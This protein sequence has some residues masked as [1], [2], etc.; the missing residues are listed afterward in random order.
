MAGLVDY[1]SSDEEGSVHEDIPQ[2]SSNTAESTLFIN[3]NTNGTTKDVQPHATKLPPAEN[4]RIIALPSN[5]K[6]DAPLVGPQ[7]GPAEAT[8]LPELEDVMNE[9][10]D[11]EPQSPYSANR[12]LLR[13]L[14]LPTVPNYDIPPSPPGSPMASTNAKF[15]HFLELK[16]QGTH[17]NEKLAK[18]A[19]LKNPSLMQKLMDFADI[20]EMEQYET[21]L[22]KYLWNPSGFPEYAYKEELA[23]TQQD[24]LMEILEQKKARGQR[25]A[26]DFV[27]A[28]ASGD[29]SHSG[30]QSAGG[31]NGKGQQ[32]AAERIMAGLD[33]G[34][35]NSPHTQGLKRK[36][37]SV[38][39]ESHRESNQASI[40]ANMPFKGGKGNLKRDRAGTIEESESYKKPRRSERLS[41]PGNTPISN[42]Q[43]LPSPVTHQE[44]S[45]SS[46][47]F[48]DGTATPPEGRP[49]QILHRTPEPTEHFFKESQ[50]FSSP[51]FCFSQVKTQEL[52]QSQTKDVEDEE[53]V[54]GYLIPVNHK[55]GELL[56]LRKRSACPLPGKNSDIGNSR[57]G[58]DLNKEEDTYEATK[59]MG[60]ASR[61]Y[62]IGRHPECDLMI[63]DIKVSNRHCLI[64]T[65]NQEGL[66][67]A[68][69][70]DLSSNGTFIK[71]NVIGRNKHRQLEDGDEIQ[72]LDDARFV[73][74]YPKLRETSKFFQKYTVLEKL[75]SGHYATV[76]LCIEKATGQRFAVKIFTRKPGIGE[77][78]KIEGLQQEI[79]MLMGVSHPYVLC[80]KDIF[81]EPDATYLVLE[82][83]AEGELFNWIVQK[84]KLTEQE[85]RKIF[86][87]LFEG[88]KYLHERGIVHRDIKPENILMTDEDLHVK[89]ADFGLAK[90]IGEASFTTTICGTPSYVAPEII[91]DSNHRRYTRA[92]DIWSLGVV[93]YICLCG[94][95]PF[96]DELY[97]RDNPYDLKA[98]IKLGRFDYPSPYW[99][100]VGDPALDL[101]DH[102]LTVDPENRY[103]VEECLAHPW[104]TQK[105]IN[106]HDSTD[107]LVGGLA[108]LDF[109]KRKIVRERT[110]LS[111]INEVKVSKIIRIEP[112]KDPVKVYVKN[113]DAKSNCINQPASQEAPKQNGVKSEQVPAA[114][115]DPKEFIKMGGKGDQTLFDNGGESIYPEDLEAK[116]KSPE[117]KAPVSK[118][119]KSKT[120]KPNK[121][122]SKTSKKKGK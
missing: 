51:P 44:S 7:L 80:L 73:F 116:V 66:N 48:R 45:S 16:K 95:P 114:Q 60:I 85:T 111:A 71:E 53:G 10:R 46:D 37:S 2:K 4:S 17:F 76:Y 13:D 88:L 62:L 52:S 26:L 109:S 42:K 33:R 117:M 18:S 47:H 14:T 1:G 35:S 61:G 63:D 104:M 39:L 25:E 64:Y 77:K 15:K 89:L 59:I 8:G 120:T 115:R 28:T 94:F 29:A 86:V 96:S 98:Q 113:S 78:Q 23:T 75:G 67:V 101:I 3:S 22:P 27:P 87:Q 21:T 74:R 11:G 43:H 12:A 112:D 93:L 19:A 58:K 92:V 32:S 110:L 122:K 83:A 31:I 79:A 99:D 65:E 57:E 50:A 9:E 118:T 20:D 81:D 5:P 91:Q 55:Y 72:V 6:S 108:G 68:V 84:G 38:R 70:E 30:T 97:S 105:T 54:W 90:I 24:I 34:R 121:P 119:P 36:T 49:S 102:M 100:T 107:G 82:L 69:V 41:Q 103:T 40:Y 56:T 106:L